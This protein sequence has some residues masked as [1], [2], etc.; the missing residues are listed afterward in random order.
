M[1]GMAVVLTKAMAFVLII[2]TGYGLKRLKVFEAKDFKVLSTIVIKITLPAAIVSNFSNMQMDN[3]LL[4]MCLIGFLANVILVLL[5]YLTHLGRSSEEKAFAMLNMSGYNIGNF[6]LPFIQ[7]FLGATGFAA[8][9]LFDAGNALM[10]TGASYTA[11]AAVA[12]TGEGV[13]VRSVLKSLFSSVPFDMYILMT[14]LAVFGIRL[15]AVVV[16]YAA[17]VGNANAFMALFMIGIGF[18]LHLEKHQIKE[19]ITILLFRY[20][21]ALIASLAAYWLLPFSREIRQTLAIVAFGPVSSVAPAF[22]GRLGGD[23]ALA[24]T[25]NSLSIIVSIILLTAA[26]IVVL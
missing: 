11:A 21:T 7:N 2:I 14:L 9:S 4:I 6:T 20:G 19:I 3:N 13:S 18:E 26:L 17:T 12:G 24:S 25:V 23:V 15:P 1:N 22:T 8:T 5:G 10:C 16:S